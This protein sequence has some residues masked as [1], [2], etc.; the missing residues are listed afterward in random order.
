MSVVHDMFAD[1][2]CS[3]TH[4]CLCEPYN[5]H[6]ANPFYYCP[7]HYILYLKSFLEKEKEYKW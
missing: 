3:I 4:C 7:S 5:C 2:E 6:H 1:R